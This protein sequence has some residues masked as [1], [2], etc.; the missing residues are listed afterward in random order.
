[1]RVISVVSRNFAPLILSLHLGVAKAADVPPTAVL[2]QI[3]RKLNG[4]DVHPRASVDF[5]RQ[6]SVG[7][8]S[9]CQMQPSEMQLR[10]NNKLLRSYSV[11]LDHQGSTNTE[12]RELFAALTRLTV[13]SDG[14]ARAYHPEDPEGEGVCRRMPTP[15]GGVLA[16]GVCAIARLR[17]SGTFI[18][19][20]VERLE[21]QDL[22]RE[23]KEIWPRI[24]NRELKSID[25]QEVMT[26][27]V[28]T[29][30]YLFYWDAR[31]LTAVFQDDIIPKDFAG[32]PCSRGA[33]SKYPGYFVAAT[34][35]RDDTAVVRPDGCKPS[36]FIDA[37]AIPFI[38]LPKGGFGLI[39]VGDV[40]VA[41]IERNGVGRFVPGV[42]ADV[43]PIGRMGEGSIALNAALL[44]Q[45]GPVLSM[46]EP[47][48]LDISG[49]SVSILVIGGTR[50]KL[51]GDYSR[52]NIERVAD[53]E[54]T[55]WGNGNFVSRFE[56]CKAM[57]V[58][59]KQ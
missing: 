48:N 8:N 9:I 37:E 17:D 27:A 29:G 32:Y 56:N 13:D 59:N 44:N 36:S 28:P 25:L 43:G 39:G 49:S 20:G 58:V 10:R 52:E 22:I 50:A 47:W 3:V 18:F 57:A 33:E 46:R 45:T 23:W 54:M 19:R 55:R 31:K 26:T 12:P 6:T 5:V 4:G 53:G 51:N 7:S 2:T 21:R 38:A 42:V 15:E 30:A 41:H 34:A 24:R 40:F 1:M 35:L 14:A 11:L 16:A